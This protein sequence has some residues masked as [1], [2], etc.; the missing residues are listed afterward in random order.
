MTD[1]LDPR[2]SVSGA[3]TTEEYLRA[4]AQGANIPHRIASWPESPYYHPVWSPRVKE[5]RWNGTPLKD[6][7]EFDVDQGWADQMVRNP[8][9][10][11]EVLIAGIARPRRRHGKI[12]VDFRMP[13]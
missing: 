9:D 6:V 4:V 10:R 3:H 2:L 13:E 12:D 5:V 8:R 7:L 1:A 11:S